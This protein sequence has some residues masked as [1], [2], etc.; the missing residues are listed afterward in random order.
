[1][2]EQTIKIK[3]YDVHPNGVVKISALQKYMQQ[4]AREDSDSY[5]ATYAKMRDAN[6]AVSYTHLRAHET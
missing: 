3:S 5:G 2:L 4:I 6:M 1:M